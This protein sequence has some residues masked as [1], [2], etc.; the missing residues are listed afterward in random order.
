MSDNKIQAGEIRPYGKMKVPRLTQQLI[1]LVKSGK[2]YSLEQII[3]PGIPYWS[4]HQ[5]LVITSLLRHGDS[6][7]F[8]PTSI[9]NEFVSLPMHGST[10][11]DALCHIGKFEGDEV[12]LFDGVDAAPNQKN[13][14]Q[15][16]YGAENFPPLVMRGILLDIASSKNLDILPASY[17][18]TGKDI[19]DCEEKQGVKIAENTAVLIRTGYEK[20]WL[21][22]NAKFSGE[23]AGL[24]LDGARYIVSKGAAVVGAD[25]EA[26]DQM[27]PC[28]AG[29]PV[30]QYLI[31]DNGVTHIEALHLEE[32]AREQIYEFLFICLPLRIKGA[33][34]SIV[35]PIA[36][37]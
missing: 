21:T 9:A 33:T 22:N 6:R 27:P 32:L 16:A 36:I 17:G 12:K 7:D 26:V 10:H 8:Y 1:S 30:H 15:N 18:F 35:H 29:L 5:P 20:Y 14:G 24:N 25:N 3:E 34:G 19:E 11:I 2:I 28:G 37:G 31:V 23:A 4:G 13:F